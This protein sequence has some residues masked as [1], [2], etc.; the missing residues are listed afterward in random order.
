MARGCPEDNHNQVFLDVVEVM[1][2][3]DGD[4]DN[5]AGA[6]GSFLAP[7]GD[8]PAAA[9]NVVD[10]IFR[11]WLLGVDRAG[12]PDG[13]TKAEGAC[14][15]D[16]CVNVPRAWP[17]GDELGRLKGMHAANISAAQVPRKS[18]LLARDR[19][20]PARTDLNT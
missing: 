18:Q 17:G 9:Y 2:D 13:E 4:E 10:L 5:A 3:P 20:Q 11:V 7:D 1:I 8:A 19:Y 15:E 14:V 6:D 16:V 12:R